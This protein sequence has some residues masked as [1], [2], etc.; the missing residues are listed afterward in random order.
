MPWCGQGVCPS[1]FWAPTSGNLIALN[2]RAEPLI[3]SVAFGYLSYDGA[4]GQLRQTELRVPARGKAVV[5]SCPVPD[6]AACARG[7]IVALAAEDG[8]LRSAWWRQGNYRSAGIPAA[9]V[10][11]ERVE[12]RGAD[13]L[14]TVAAQGFAHAVHLLLDDDMRPEDQYFDLLPGEARTILVPDAA[15]GIGNDVSV[16]WINASAAKE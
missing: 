8:A 15:A 9:V 14:V 1:R 4:V 7:T 16:R 6:V 13:L 12:R 10:A 5:A 3:A 11:V 2:D